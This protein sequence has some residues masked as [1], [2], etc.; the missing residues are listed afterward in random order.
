MIE[1]LEKNL[2]DLLRDLG[3]GDVPG[4]RRVAELQLS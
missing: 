2:R 3:S 1:E 4:I